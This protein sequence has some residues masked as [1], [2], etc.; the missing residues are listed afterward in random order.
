[1]A[2][3]LDLLVCGFEGLWFKS[4]HGKNIDFFFILG[5]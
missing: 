1:M 2:E 5:Y 3:F 4:W